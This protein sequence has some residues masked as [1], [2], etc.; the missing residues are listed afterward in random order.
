MAPQNPNHAVPQCTP[1]PPPP[2]QPIHNP[3]TN[4]YSSPPKST[5]KSKPASVVS[6]PKVSSQSFDHNLSPS[7]SR[8]RF[9]ALARRQQQMGEWEDDYTYHTSKVQSSHCNVTQ[10]PAKSTPVVHELNFCEEIKAKASNSPLKKTAEVEHSPAKAP[11]HVNDSNVKNS[12]KIFTAKGAST[13]LDGVVF[14]A[15]PAAK[16]LPVTHERHRELSP[17]E[18]RFW[19]SKLIHSL[20]SLRTILFSSHSLLLKKLG[21]VW[22]FVCE[23]TFSL[24]L[25]LCKLRLKDV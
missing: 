16:V 10:P 8:S 2:P 1:P 21:I 18:K 6:E 24:Q 20:V 4:N 19:D 3:Q 5:P 12:P 9:T 15:T 23:V 25:F 17:S 13:N 14:N 22:F 11:Q 7:K